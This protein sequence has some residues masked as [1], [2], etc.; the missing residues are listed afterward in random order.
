M[1]FFAKDLQNLLIQEQNHSVSPL[2]MLMLLRPCSFRDSA[3]VSGI[4][5]P[6]QQAVCVFGDTVYV[7]QTQH[8]DLNS[9]VQDTAPWPKHNSIYVRKLQ[10]YV[11]K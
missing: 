10:N 4:N 3:A 8:S 2:S 1:Y 7:S 9:H 11:L 6:I 5:P